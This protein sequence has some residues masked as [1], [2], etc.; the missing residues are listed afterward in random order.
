MIY[1]GLF[2]Q[3]VPKFETQIE[4][5]NSN[6]NSKLKLKSETQNSKAKLETQI[7]TQNSEVKTQIDTQN[8]KLKFKLKS[9][10]ETQN[11]KSKLKFKTQIKTHNSNLNSSCRPHTVIFQEKKTKKSTISQ[12]KS[13]FCEIKALFA[14]LKIC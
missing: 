9:Q 10:I 1:Q 6:R 14:L 13:I 7:E 2:F 8:S 5:Q 12:N 11:S 3:K 4:T